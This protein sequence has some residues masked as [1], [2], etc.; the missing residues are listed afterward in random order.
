MED[1]NKFKA[2]LMNNMYEACCGINNDFI[3]NIKYSFREVDELSLTVPNIIMEEMERKE[4]YCF[5][6]FRGK[7]QQIIIENGNNKESNIQK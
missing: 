5:K 4:N 3:N 6:K 7:N 2:I 1:K